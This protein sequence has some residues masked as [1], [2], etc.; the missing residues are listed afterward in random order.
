MTTTVLMPWDGE[1]EEW[2]MD[3]LNS[4]TPGTPFKVA[5]NAS[6]VEM[7][8]ALND[9]LA[10][11]DTEF[12]FLMGADDLATPGM[13]ETLEAGVGDS[14]GAYPVM[15]LFGDRE[16]T[17][18]PP[19]WS[20]HILQ[21]RNI[22]GV[23]LIRTAALKAV[24]GWRN[25][26]IEDWEL[27]VRLAKSGLRM[28]RCLGA[29]YMYRQHAA[30][31]TQRIE[32]AAKVEGFSQADQMKEILG[33]KLE[34]YPLGAVFYGQAS[35]AQN[36]VRGVV[37]A[38][39]LPGVCSDLL[40][41]HNLG[42]PA[43]VW[44]YPGTG[45]Y[46][47]AFGSDDYG[48]R[49]ADVDDNYLSPRLIRELERAGRFDLAKSWA[50]EQPGHEAFV[51]DADAVFCA[52][53]HLVDVYSE[54]NDQVFL[55]RNSVLEADWRRVRT[56]NDDLKVRI[57]WAAGGQHG[58]DAPIVASALRSIVKRHPE[59]EV[60]VVG[61]DPGWD[62]PYIVE[63][64]T[65]TLS[66]YRQRLATFD[67]ALAPLKRTDMNRGK[68]DLKWLD[69]T[70]AGAAFVC[71]DYEPYDTVEHDVTGLKCAAAPDWEAAIEALVVDADYRRD[72]RRCAL[73]TILETRTAEQVS[74]L[75]RDA[76][77]SL[78]VK[79]CVAA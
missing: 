39:H 56:G 49:I 3:A 58:P 72:L 63:P 26:V 64:F 60:V 15:E 6:K 2:L 55:L 77:A 36:Y 14:D 68:S 73:D 17:Y 43:S 9:A 46:D 54:K 69:S 12:T 22:C 48:F 23:F 53:P 44:L 24:G 79:G 20:R 62:F 65:K 4:L 35:G 5:Q 71:S 51:R 29:K 76:L 34:R 78:N 38:E 42:A 45:S 31:L 61:L 11:I 8:F 25:A 18:T 13:I 74:N 70:M 37:P 41:S 52:T 33:D 32:H 47:Q 66:V 1:N 40:W 67:I 57:G 21:Y 59:V 27:M 19:I 30:S 50:K 10:E 16:Y 7:T 75:Y 28:E